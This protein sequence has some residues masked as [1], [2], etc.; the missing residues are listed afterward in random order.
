MDRA[1]LARVEK[2]AWFH[3]F[4]RGLP[5]AMFVIALAATVLC[6]MVIER[7]DRQARQ[8]ELE[9]NATE[10]ATALQR[11]AAESIA[12]L[13]AGAALFATQENVD[14]GRF[15]DFT[16]LVNHDHQQRG[17]LG[18]GWAQRIWSWEV[19]TYEEALRGSYSFD[20]KVRPT[21]KW[22]DQALVPITY[23]EPQTPDNLRALG[24]DLYSEANRRVAIDTAARTGRPVVTGRVQ[25]IQDQGRA[26]A[27]YYDPLRTWINACH[28]RG[29]TAHAGFEMLVQQVPEYLSF[30]GYESI[31]RAVR[32]DPSEVRALLTPA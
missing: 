2:Q 11:R 30:F 13:N 28:A 3:R 5:V 9:R 22:P 32:A 29:I 7:L 24:F 19:G 14:L 25:L 20:L 21:P 12:F 23:L 6:V 17:L 31:A 26:P 18:I 10:V 4:P 8:V 15:R 1:L 16:S 27:P